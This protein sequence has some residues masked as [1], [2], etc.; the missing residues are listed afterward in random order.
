MGVGK[1]ISN[2]YC[3]RC[4]HESLHIGL[5]CR[6]CGKP[7]KWQTK[8]Y[9]PQYNPHVNQN[10]ALEARKRAKRLREAARRN[11]IYTPTRGSR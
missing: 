4:K 10:A 9:V 3:P 7:H 8:D 6:D 5:I 1:A 11:K 2:F